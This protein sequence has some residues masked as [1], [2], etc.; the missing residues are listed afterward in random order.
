MTLYNIAQID[1]IF[2]R[3]DDIPTKRQIYQ[4]STEHD[5]VI[6]NRRASKLPQ[7]DDKREWLYPP[8]CRAVPPG[9]LE[10]LQEAQKIR[11]K[12]REEEKAKDPDF[13]DPLEVLDYDI[14]DPVKGVPMDQV[15]FHTLFFGFAPT[16]M[17]IRCSISS[18]LKTS[19]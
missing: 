8:H 6:R 12:L 15:N 17:G 4:W 2:P 10:D 11:R 7:R 19:A 9:N 3:A 14:I 13:V 18:H 1:T 16:D 5:E